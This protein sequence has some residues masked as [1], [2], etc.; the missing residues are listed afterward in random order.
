MEILHCVSEMRRFHPVIIIVIFSN[1]N[2]L[3][4]SK[5]HNAIHQLSDIVSD[6]NNKPMIVVVDTEKKQ[7]DDFDDLLVDG[8]DGLIDDDSHQKTDASED[9]AYI[10]YHLLRTTKQDDEP[11]PLLEETKHALR[12]AI[13]IKCKRVEE[14]IIECPPRR[15]SCPRNCQEVFDNL[16]L[17]PPPRPKRPK[18]D[19]RPKCGKTMPPK[20]FF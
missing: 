3:K 7:R 10:L 13:K 9:A 2:S 4:I 14:C 12:Q 6:K 18:N 5:P 15:P 16:N 20:W 8:D 11:D 19:C 1:V 17:C